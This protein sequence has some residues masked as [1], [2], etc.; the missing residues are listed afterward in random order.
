MNY[1]K[2]VIVMIFIGLIGAGIYKY[3][4]DRYNQGYSEAETDYLKANDDAR[5]LYERD[6][7][8]LSQDAIQESGKRKE[9]EKR[10]QELLRK[11]PEVRIHEVIREIPCDRV[12]DGIKRM[13][14]SYREAS[15]SINGTD[16]D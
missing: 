5:A 1:A 2:I 12:G 11:E 8:K 7:A 14:D 9:A 4:S 3:G 16:A 10:I 13:W 15:L 6:I